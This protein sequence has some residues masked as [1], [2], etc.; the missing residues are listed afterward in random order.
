MSTQFTPFNNLLSWADATVDTNGQPLP[1]DET[2]VLTTIGVRSDGDTAHGPGNYA[3]TVDV[4]AP[5][6]QISRKDFDAAVTGKY[7]KPLP[8]GNYWFNAQ[9]E[10]VEGGVDATSAW[11]AVET[12]VNIPVVPVTPAAPSPFV[13][14]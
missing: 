13:V 10:D 1:A 12:A 3:W 6:A 8:P 11:G 5:A 7:S 9:Q 14:S 4:N 2:L